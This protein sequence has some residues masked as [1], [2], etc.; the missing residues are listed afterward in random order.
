MMGVDPQR[1]RLQVFGRLLAA[2]DTAAVRGRDGCPCDVRDFL[3]R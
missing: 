1:L 3:D 2:A